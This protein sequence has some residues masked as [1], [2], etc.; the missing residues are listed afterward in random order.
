VLISPQGYRLFQVNIESANSCFS[1]DKLRPISNLK[2]RN[3]STRGASLF[4]FEL[5]SLSHEAVEIG[6][7]V[8]L[9]QDG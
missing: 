9:A 4:P 5:K 1:S 2:L 3:K 7:E 6:G 8:Q